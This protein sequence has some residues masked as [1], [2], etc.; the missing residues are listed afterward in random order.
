ML[1]SEWH[2]GLPEKPGEYI[3]KVKWP[4]DAVKATLSHDG[5]GRPVLRTEFLVPPEHVAAWAEILK[6]ITKSEPA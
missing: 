6:P 3:V 4:C 5:E 2:A 1:I